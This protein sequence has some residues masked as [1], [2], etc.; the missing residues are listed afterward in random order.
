MKRGDW[1]LYVALGVLLLTSIGFFTWAWQAAA[2]R[3]AVPFRDEMFDKMMR[4]KEQA[5]Q[6]IEQG[7]SQSDYRRMETGIIHLHHLPVP[8]DWYA[9]DALYR[10]NSDDFRQTLDRLD[11]SVQ[12]R[13]LE[14]SRRAYAE[15]RARDAALPLALREDSVDQRVA[16]PAHLPRRRRDDHLGDDDSL[17]GLPLLSQ[18]R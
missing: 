8:A 6:T 12:E 14:A 9:A 5:A 16:A 11:R 17:V 3:D 2:K 7:I 18:V 15:L 13:D 4:Q 1:I 10:Q